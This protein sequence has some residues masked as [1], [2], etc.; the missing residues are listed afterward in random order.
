MAISMCWTWHLSHRMWP[1][2]PS[3]TRQNNMKTTVRIFFLSLVALCTASASSVELFPPLVIPTGV[4]FDVGVLFTSD[5]MQ[6]YQF[7]LLFPTFLQA[8]SVTGSGFFAASALTSG[9]I[10]NSSGLIFIFG[11]LDSGG[12]DCA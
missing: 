2:A 7:D 6:G 10:D 1:R 4:T 12:S 9:S 11:L 8:N 5:G 3:A